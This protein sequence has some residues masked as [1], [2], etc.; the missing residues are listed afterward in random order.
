MKLLNIL[1][2]PWAI[3]PEKLREIRAVYETH[4]KGEKIDIEGLEAKFDLSFQSGQSAGDDLYSTDNGV[5]VINIEGVITK[6]LNLFCCLFGGTSTEL[7]GEAIKA[8]IA[9]PE[10]DSI[11]LYVDSPGGS[12]DGTAELAELIY[13]LRGEKP[14]TAFTDGMMASAAYWIGSAADEIYISGDTVD[15][16]SIGVIA[17][18]LDVS[19]ALDDIGFNFTLI[20]AGRYKTVGSPY[21]PLSEGDH[22]VIQSEVDYI[23]AAFV[24]AVAKHRGASE[25]DVLSDMADGRIFIGNQAVKAGLVD[26][27][28]TFDALIA[29]LIAGHDNENG[30]GYTMN[31]GAIQPKEE[32]VMPKPTG[33]ET[34]ETPVVEINAEYLGANHPGLVEAI[35]KQGFDA[36]RKEGLT[37]GAEGER[38][39][40]KAVEGQ[41]MPGHEKLIAGLKF[42]GETTGPDAAVKVLAAEK[43]KLATTHKTIV[44]EG[45]E[46]AGAI[47]TAE[48]PADQV[49]GGS[50]HVSQFDAKVAEHMKEN[51]CK[52]SEAIKAVA[53]AHPE[54]HE[55]YISAANKKGGKQR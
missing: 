33:K 46:L 43:T 51:D 13:S 45:E 50:D 1:T 55:K 47:P 24:R 21:K 4:M 39:R 6:K 23:Y 16:G 18:H 11:L 3:V 5:A 15:V 9:D 22:S 48:P 44:S 7:V 40:I 52:K 32:D 28:S 31:A 8:A 54:L 19:K 36:G 17:T 38:E 37:A 49:E 53:T 27:V 20:Q 35:K 29:D 10:V 34:K 14:I 12:V 25:A 41:F 2:A 26:N 30:A 42:D